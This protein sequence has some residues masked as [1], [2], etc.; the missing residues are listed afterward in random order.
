V[1]AAGAI[2]GVAASLALTRLIQ[3]MLVDI[4]PHDPVAFMAAVGLLLVVAVA[5]ALVPAWRAARVDPLHV[6]RES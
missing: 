3:A 1:V 2:V 6:L 4:T 5:A